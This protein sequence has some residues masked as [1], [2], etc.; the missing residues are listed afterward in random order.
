MGNLAAVSPPMVQ[1]RDVVDNSRSRAMKSL[2][3]LTVWA[4]FLVGCDSNSG[5][6]S[7]IQI[8]PLASGDGT[9]TDTAQVQATPVLISITSGPQT[10]IPQESGTISAVVVDSNGLPIAGEVVNFS[11]VVNTSGANIGSAT[12]TTNANGI[13]SISY[14]A[15][16]DAG[17][18]IIRATASNGI[19]SD[20]TVEVA[21]YTQIVGT[22]SLEPGATRVT[23]G[24]LV[25]L[26]GRVIDLDGQ[27]ITGATV[28]FYSSNGFLSD[29]TVN[30]GTTNILSAT[31]D[32]R[33]YASVTLIAP[34]LIGSSALSAESS[35]VIAQQSIAYVAGAVTSVAVSGSPDAV[36]PN[37]STTINAFVRDG[38]N[39]VAGEVVRFELATNATG[40]TLGSV[41]A[42]TNANGIASVSYTAGSS[43]GN[44]II[45][46]TTISNGV[47][48]MGNVNVGSGGTGTPK[49]ALVTISRSQIYVA[50]VGKTESTG[51][52]ISVV[53]G[54]G[55]KIDDSAY[56]DENVRLS[57]ITSPNGGGVGRERS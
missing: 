57:F 6:G 43:A 37:G 25:N 5:D 9:D 36:T 38:T 33:G 50:G 1:H 15:G 45:R 26:R 48:G 28:N 47:I 31:S 44:D 23:V 56:L 12:A 16:S 39:P 52:T 2:I 10:V 4:F 42:T 46:A 17:S 54:A 20:A 55:N 11:L 24:D 30:S 29:G 13:A 8:V 32:S 19:A 18:D 22:V 41:T 27:A 51:I 53:D 35:N 40:A 3:W 21:V 14:T 7:T 49:T 34:S